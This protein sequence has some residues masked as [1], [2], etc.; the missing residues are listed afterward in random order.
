MSCLKS[1]PDPFNSLNHMRTIDSAT[2][3]VEKHDYC[4]YYVMYCSHNANN[5]NRKDFGSNASI[6]DD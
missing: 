3:S 1:T 4:Y 5:I 6:T 2:G